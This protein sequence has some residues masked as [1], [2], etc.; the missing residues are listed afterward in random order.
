[1]VTHVRWHPAAGVVSRRFGD[2]LVLAGESLPRTITEQL[3]PWDLANL[4]P[5][6]EDYLSG[7]RSEMY[8][9]DLQ[10]GF[11][12]ACAIMAP[13][14]ETDIRRD[15]GGD[16]QRIHRRDTRYGAV[17][18]KHIL[19]PIWVSAFR[20]RDRVYR[21]VV[22]GRTGEVQGERPYSAWKIA[23]AILLGL[24]VTGSLFVLL[25]L[26]ENPEASSMFLNRLSH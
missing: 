14:I 26:H 22:N 8:R 3:E 17:S 25:R 6:Q 11:E 4:Q 18:F 23:L 15:I 21:F 7:F 5:Y 12:R 20:F 13:V 19:L 24:L 16:E 9:V 10:S 1:M 2:V